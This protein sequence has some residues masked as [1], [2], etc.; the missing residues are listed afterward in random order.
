MLPPTQ[1]MIS[2][3]SKTNVTS[4]MDD[5]SV[6]SDYNYTEVPKNNIFFCPECWDIP[7]LSLNSSNYKIISNCI[8]NN[9]HKEYYPKELCEKSIYHSLTNIS[10][11]ICHQ[12]S[13]EKILL[14]ISD[15]NKET[16]N[17][18]PLIQFLY[19]EQ[20]KD[21]FCMKCQKSHLKQKKNHLLLVA[22][23]IG[24]FCPLHNLSYSSYCFVCNRNICLNCVNKHLSHKIIP[25]SKIKPFPQEINQKKMEINRERTELKKVELIF[26]DAINQIYAKF[27]KLM[28]CK[29]EELNFK[30]NIIMTY[31]MRNNNFNSILNFINLNVNYEKFNYN[32][33]SPNGCEDEVLDDAIGVDKIKNIYEYLQNKKYTIFNNNKKNINY[34]DI[35][36]SPELDE[37]LIYPGRTNKKDMKPYTYIDNYE[38]F[39]VENKKYLE[40]ARSLDLQGNKIKKDKKQL[41]KQ[42][43]NKDNKINHYKINKNNGSEL[44]NFH[45]NSNSNINEDNNYNTNGD[46]N[47]NNGIIKNLSI[48]KS[49]NKFNYILIKNNLCI[50][51]KEEK[52]INNKKLGKITKNKDKYYTQDNKDNDQKTENKINL[53][54]KNQE[55]NKDCNINSTRTKEIIELDIKNKLEKKNSNFYV[56][57][58]SNRQA[59][60]KFSKNSERKE[61][62]RTMPYKPEKI[63]T[64]YENKKEIMNLILL[65]DGNFCTSSW[66]ATIKIFNSENYELLLKITEPNNYDVCYVLQLNDNSLILCSNC[67][68]KYKLANG[69]KDYS[70]ETKLSGYNDYLIKVIELKDNS[71]ITCDWEY[72]IRV[73]KR[74]T[75]GNSNNNQYELIKSNI[76]EGEHLCSLCRLNDYEFISSSNSHL[77]KGNDTLRF[78]DLNYNNYKTIYNISCSELIDTICQID[79]DYLCVALQKWNAKQIKGIAI[80]DLKEKQIIN[81]IQGDSMT[82]ISLI[83]SK[84]KIIITGGR[85]NT[86]KKS[87]IREWKLQNKGELIQLYEICTEQND[88]IT[89]IIKLNDGR[90][91]SSN[92]DTTI[93]ILK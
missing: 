46:I 77:E 51:S 89:S 13:Q 6:L 23:K 63:K 67:I 91:V 7:K 40:L 54:N 88:A 29:L 70:L 64:I 24:A 80:I 92:Y 18:N 3:D 26:K 68:Y 50:I 17:Q 38:D 15:K 57:K 85:D 55:E 19:C 14:S 62:N 31:E 74:I 22:S 16:I 49:W 60:L 66:D 90:I 25:F 93:V 65:H 28:E 11:N 39:D 84:E 44:I 69:D 8:E 83:N 47:E 78:Y 45:I 36:N 53:N 43:E 37:E 42:K 81:I 52:K 33:F 87:I 34:D 76:N 71:L 12:N 79:E 30:E 75:T 82:C 73:W 72:K 20:C 27:N 86:N 41:I 1:S 58:V 32:L 2:F 4:F 59:K 21:F 61:I 10:C 56:K 35:L 5:L 48:S 9:H